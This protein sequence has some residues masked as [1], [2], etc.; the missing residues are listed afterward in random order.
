V[1]AGILLL[2]TTENLRYRECVLRNVRYNTV[3]ELQEHF[4]ANHRAIFDVVDLVGRG[5]HD[6][7]QNIPSAEAINQLYQDYRVQLFGFVKE[8]QHHVTFH[9]CFLLHVCE[10]L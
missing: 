10:C 4:Q 6:L 2:A 9:F 7:P 5:Y 3:V 8:N 1:T